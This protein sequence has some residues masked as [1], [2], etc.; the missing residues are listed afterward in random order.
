MEV[1]I[2]E[3]EPATYDP[4]DPYDIPYDYWIVAKLNNGQ[5]INILVDA[6]D[7]TEL[8]GKKAKFYI[9]AKEALEYPEKKVFTTSGNYHSKYKISIDE[10]EKFFMYDLIPEKTTKEEYFK[11]FLEGRPALTTENGTYFASENPSYNDGD[12]IDYNVLQFYPSFW[13]PIDD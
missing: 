1:F 3:V 7:L 13:Y 8:K 2:E 11:D 10:I 6:Y 12:L 9:Y 5:R 4:D